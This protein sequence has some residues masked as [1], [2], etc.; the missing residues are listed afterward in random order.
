MLVGKKKGINGTR[1]GRCKYY[2]NILWTYLKYNMK[3]AYYV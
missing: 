1:S 3:I 2:Q